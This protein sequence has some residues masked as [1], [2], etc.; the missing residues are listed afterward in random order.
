MA[1]YVI[2]KKLELLCILALRML[3]HLQA[4]HIGTICLGRCS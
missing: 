3:V 2:E 1:Q 4:E